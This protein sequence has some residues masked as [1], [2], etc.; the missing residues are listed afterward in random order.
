MIEMED[1][2]IRVDAQIV[3]EGLAID[4][5]LLQQRMREGMITSLCER[6]IDEDKG[7]YRLTFFSQNKRFRLI[8]DEQGS[9]LQRT[10]L[11]V[12]GRARPGLRADRT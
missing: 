10:T 5:S 3:A 8:V 12:G 4:P 7:R 6:G 1:G 2:T 9:V 11:N